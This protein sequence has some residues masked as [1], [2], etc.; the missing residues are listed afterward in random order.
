MTALTLG[1]NCVAR[2]RCIRQSKEWVLAPRY[3]HIHRFTLSTGRTGLS[4][5]WTKARLY[6]ACLKDAGDTAPLIACSLGEEEA[7]GW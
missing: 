5:Q 4:D 3:E 1:V 6:H 7:W 2:L